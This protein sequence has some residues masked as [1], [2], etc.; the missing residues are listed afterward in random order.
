MTMAK[1][2]LDTTARLGDLKGSW[3]RFW[4]WWRGQLSSLL[5]EAWRRTF[6]T[7][8]APVL[9][10][11]QQGHLHLVSA[12]GEIPLDD[13]S[14]PLPAATLQQ[15]ERQANKAEVM[16]L[17]PADR[18]LRKTLSLPLATEPR[19]ADVLGFE[20]NRHTPF[21]GDQVYFGFRVKSRDNQAGML[22]LDLLVATRQLLDP[23]LDKLKTLG[24][25]PG[26]VSLDSPDQPPMILLGTRTARQGRRLGLL[27]LLPLALVLGLLWLK[28][29]HIASLEA[30]L[31]VPQAAAEKAMAAKQQI[32]LLTEGSQILLTRKG[33]DIPMLMV[34]D[35]LTRLLPDQ[36]WLTRLELQKGQLSIQGESSNASA[37][38]GLLDA[39]P[40]FENVSFASPVTLNSR[41]QKERF[42]ISAQLSQQGKAP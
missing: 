16:L 20:M 32:R 3:G 5:P 13:D 30:E 14:R 8:K 22:S 26:R 31:A 10:S 21:Q 2:Q 36:T 25:A 1:G 38:I 19:L 28:H 41:T 27:W 24:L 33:Q 17:L 39:S 15:L 37:L 40:L 11:Y 12:N 35:E 6:S 29:R 42:V 7:S 4:H 23:L 18:M 34:L 9:L